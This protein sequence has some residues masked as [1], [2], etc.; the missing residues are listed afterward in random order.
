MPASGVPVSDQ[1]ATGQP[2]ARQITAGSEAS[3]KAWL[4]VASIGYLLGGL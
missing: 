4:E 1:V 3:A 2:D